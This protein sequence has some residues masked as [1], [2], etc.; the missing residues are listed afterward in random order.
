MILQVAVPHKVI[1]K[2][3]SEVNTCIQE[4]ANPETS[5]EEN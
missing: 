2:F 5:Q 3:L 4:I 1:W